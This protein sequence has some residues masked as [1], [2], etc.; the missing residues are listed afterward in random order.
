M[1]SAR[2]HFV[3]FLRK[4]FSR[5]LPNAI[6]P[7][8]NRFPSLLAGQRKPPRPLLL[9][10]ARVAEAAR[11]LGR[12]RPERA[13]GASSMVKLDRAR[14]RLYRSEILQEN[15]RLKALA[16]IY[17][18]L[19]FAQLCNLNLSNFLSK[20]RKFAKQFVQLIFAN[21]NTKF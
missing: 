3:F 1:H 8:R 5:V 21:L 9:A 17:T 4:V 19:S 10:R 13:A 16:E 12:E 11:I 7:L 20:S 14:S 15:M 18:L 2:F 6:F